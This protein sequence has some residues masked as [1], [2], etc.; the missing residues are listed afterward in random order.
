MTDLILVLAFVG[1]LY[2]AYKVGQASETVREVE[3][4]GRRRIGL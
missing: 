1:T 3:S 2:I 4:H